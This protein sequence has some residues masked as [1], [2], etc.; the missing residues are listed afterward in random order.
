MMREGMIELYLS[1]NI[2][3]EDEVIWIEELFQSLHFRLQRNPNFTSDDM[4]NRV[5]LFG[6]ACAKAL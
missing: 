6:R 5:S 2:S 3:E 1:H 4:L